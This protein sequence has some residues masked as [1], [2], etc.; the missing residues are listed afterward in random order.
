MICM[1][2]KNDIYIKVIVIKKEFDTIIFMIFENDFVN[3]L[4]KMIS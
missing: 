1:I 4:R 3:E 2:L